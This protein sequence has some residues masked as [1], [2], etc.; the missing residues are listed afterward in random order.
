M[1]SAEKIKRSWRGERV[2][3]GMYSSGEDGRERLPEL[4]H[5]SEDLKE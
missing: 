2:E 5:L 4:G 3:G 1:R